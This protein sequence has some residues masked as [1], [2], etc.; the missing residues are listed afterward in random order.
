MPFDPWTR[1]RRLAKYLPDVGWD[2]TVLAAWQ[3]NGGLEYGGPDDALQLDVITTR[4]VEWVPAV[5]LAARALPPVRAALERLLRPARRPSP[6]PATHSAPNVSAMSA[7]RHSPPFMLSGSRLPD[8]YTGWIPY[9]VHAG[10][11]FIREHDVDLIYASGMPTVSLCVGALLHYR[12]GVPWIAE[13]RDAW[14]TNFWAWRPRGWQQA[15]EAIERLVVRSASAIIGLSRPLA[16]DLARLHGRPVEVVTNG[17]DPAD[18]AERPPL[19]PHLTI[20]HTGG[21]APWRRVAPFMEAV[22]TLLHQGLMPADVRLRYW[23]RNPEYFS[24]AAEHVG[25]APHVELHA[26]VAPSVASRC[27]QESTIL[28]LVESVAPEARLMTTAKLFDYLAAG[29]PILAFAPRGGAADAILRETGAGVVVES[30]QEATAVLRRWLMAYRRGDLTLGLQPDP[31]AIARYAWPQLVHSLVGLFE[32]AC[33]GKR[34][35]AQGRG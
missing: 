1:V 13:Y 34:A 4:W 6:A 2:A 21:L 22:T 11:R 19:T 24:A 9:A 12:T 5:T 31:A 18:Y 30:A 16:D 7:R 8:V 14:T 20:S 10:E 35:L 25:L 26:E 33:A 17:F 32:Q 23:G 3:K 29:R 27:Q 28:L 15:E